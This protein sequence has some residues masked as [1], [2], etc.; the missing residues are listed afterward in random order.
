MKHTASDHNKVVY[1]Y[2]LNTNASDSGPVWENYNRK[3]AEF[4]PI[5]YS[6]LCLFPRY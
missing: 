5:L 4:I 3:G 2:S 6:H 1:S